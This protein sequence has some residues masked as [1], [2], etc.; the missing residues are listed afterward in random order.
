MIDVR[1]NLIRAAGRMRPNPA[2]PYL[3]VPAQWNCQGE[4]IAIGLIDTGCDVHAADLSGA[5]L[6]V[7]S[8]A[9]AEPPAEAVGHAT[10]SVT[11]LL[12]QGRRR[13]RGITPDAQVLLA[14]VVGCDGRASVQAVA[15]ALEWLLSRHVP[16]V[17][18]PFGGGP[19]LEVAR[20]IEH[21]SKTGTLFF[22]AAGN[23]Y[24]EAVL[25]PASHAS[26][27]AVGAADDRGK[28]LPECC[29]Y[30]RLDLVA[31]GWRV[32]SIIQ[33]QVVRRRSGTSVA[34]AV[35]AGVGALAMSAGVLTKGQV[36]REKVCAALCAPSFQ[37][38]AGR[39]GHN[40]VVS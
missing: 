39:S 24:P 7:K 25:F 27:L 36:C 40:K 29:R 13:I 10:H 33:G 11:L 38:P 37:T 9:G 15:G 23:R 26:V 3:R 35:A 31:P 28:L 16:I 20:L 8:F 1:T 2:L 4:G 12:G 6:E 17:A 30:P 5:R 14:N 32:A 18:M 34:C 21:G 19:Q 22:A